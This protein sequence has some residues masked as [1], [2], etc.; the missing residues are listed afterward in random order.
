TF[1][2]VAAVFF[3]LNGRSRE[4]APASG[5]K[6]YAQTFGPGVWQRSHPTEEVLGKVH[7]W[8]NSNLVR[9][10]KNEENV[11]LRF[12]PK[13]VRDAAFPFRTAFVAQELQADVKD[14]LSALVSA[15]VHNLDSAIQKLLGAEEFRDHERY[16][17][18]RSALLAEVK[19]M[20]TLGSLNV[21]REP[22]S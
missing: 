16:E 2:V 18:V 7:Y 4:Q 17:E 13:S 15:P 21:G 14:F 3:I 1:S 20:Q 5:T 12:E 19:R 10:T 22:V 11:G 8:F 6:Y 9:S